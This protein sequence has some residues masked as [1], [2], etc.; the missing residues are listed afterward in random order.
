M[1]KIYQGKP[2]NNIPT[3]VRILI[4]IPAFASACCRDLDSSKTNSVREP[5]E[6]CGLDLQI[7]TVSLKEVE[8]I[9]AGSQSNPAASADSCASLRNRNTPIS[10]P[11]FD[12]RSQ[13]ASGNLFGRFDPPSFAT[14]RLAISH[15]KDGLY[16]VSHRV[17]TRSAGVRLHASSLR[18]NSRHR[19]PRRR[20][21][22]RRRR[23]PQHQPHLRRRRSRQQRCPASYRHRRLQ[24]H[25]N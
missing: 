14:L 24:Q 8:I 2:C 19:H 3:I 15:F 9:Y 13:S 7:F 21:S 6:I 12:P 5:A 4:A 25:R 17:P 11:V 20:I 10:C 23:Q 22:L 1:P 18:A 16:A